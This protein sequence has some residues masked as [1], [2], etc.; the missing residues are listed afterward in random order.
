MRVARS[1]GGIALLA[2]PRARGCLRACGEDFGAGVSGAVWEMV[3]NV[4]SGMPPMWMPGSDGVVGG[5]DNVF[6][7][8]EFTVPALRKTHDLV[9]A[10]RPQLC[11]NAD[12]R[13]IVNKT[14]EQLLGGGLRKR[15]AEELLGAGLAGFVSEDQA[16]A[17]DA[18]NR[19]QPLSA[20]KASNRLSKE[21]A[22]I[23]E[24][25]AAAQAARVSG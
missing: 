1:G 24:N 5:S 22:R 7:V 20:G 6:V 17:R 8:T 9:S 23:L 12:A 11:A 4:A 16:L 2:G 21:L 18:I 10:L 19:G 3:A 14:H 25:S 15:D 13:V